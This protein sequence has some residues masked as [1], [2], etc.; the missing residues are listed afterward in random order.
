MEGAWAPDRVQAPDEPARI[1]SGG[2]PEGSGS[3]HGRIYR[4]LR[5][6]FRTSCRLPAADDSILYGSRRR[7]R[8]DAVDVSEPALQRADGSRGDAAGRAFRAGAWSTV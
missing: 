7:G 5:C 6:R 1:Q 3:S 4:N 8:P 2:A